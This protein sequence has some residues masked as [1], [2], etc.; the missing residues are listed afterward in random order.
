M[1]TMAGGR[2]TFDERDQWRRLFAM[3]DR[4]DR[5]SPWP[6]MGAADCFGVAVPG[7]DEPCFVVFGGR[8]GSLIVTRLRYSLTGASRPSSRSFPLRS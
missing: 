7:W 8:P 1:D 6:W 4:L 2:M 5:L 3:A